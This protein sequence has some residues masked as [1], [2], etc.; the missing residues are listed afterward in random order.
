M[1]LVVFCPTLLPDEALNHPGDAG[2]TYPEPDYVPTGVSPDPAH[3]PMTS[4]ADKSSGGSF[5]LILYKAY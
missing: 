5:I 3:H 4:T 1:G 2:K